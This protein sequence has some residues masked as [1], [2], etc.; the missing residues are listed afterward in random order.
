VR[1]LALPQPGRIRELF[2]LVSRLHASLLDRHRPLWEIYL[3]EGLADGR[4]ALYTKVHHSMLDGIAAVRQIL[5]SFSP[6]PQV[7][8]LPPPWASNPASAHDLHALACAAAR[9][10]GGGS[11]HW[12][13]AP[14]SQGGRSTR[15]GHGGGAA[16]PHGVRRS[17][18]CPP[19]PRSHRSPRR[20]RC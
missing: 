3:I 4:V 18:R 16:Q 12:P 13:A 1:H 2:S 19:M 17:P 11:P 5:A 9:A 8:D 6:D 15:A 7:R 20:R 10:D 14:G